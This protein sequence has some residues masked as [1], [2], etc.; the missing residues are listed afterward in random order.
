MSR[1][2]AREKAF[3]FLYQIQVH[4]D[5]Y[6]EQLELFWVRMDEEGKLKEDEREYV[7]GLI[8]GVREHEKE[9]DEIISRYLRNW[10][11]ERLPKVELA[12]LR[13]SVYEICFAGE[14]YGVCVNEAVRL[15]KLYSNPESKKYINGLLAQ[16]DPDRGGPEAEKREEGESVGG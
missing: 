9:V 10:K 8:A 12:I 2:L 3:Q 6:P 16:L 4:E 1:Y 15:T 7:S 5:H 11:I 14:P 13:L